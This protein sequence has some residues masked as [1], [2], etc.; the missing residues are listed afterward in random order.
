MALSLGIDTGGTY[1]DAVLFEEDAGVIATA[2][3]LTTRHDFS[4]GIGQ[5]IGAVIG[6]SKIDPSEISLVSL[7]STLATNALVE[8]QGGRVCLVLIGFDRSALSRSG[9]AEAIKDDPVILLEGGHNANGDEVAKP[10]LDELRPRLRELEGEVS[11]YAVAG[12]FGVRNPEHEIQVRDTIIDITSRP[13]TCS[14]ELSSKLDGPRRALTCVLNARLINMVHHLISATEVQFAER[15]IHAPLMVVQGDGAL[16]SSDIAKLKP[17]ETILS[18]PAASLVG[19][20]WLTGL[21]DALISDIG[22]TTTDIAILKDGTPRLDEDGATVGGWRT[23]VEAVA[24]H[25]VGLGGDSEV[26]VVQRGLKTELRLGPRRL[27]PLSL[28][29]TDYPDLVHDTLI[30]QFNQPALGEHDGQFAVVVGRESAHLTALSAPESEILEL[31]NHAPQAL[32]KVISSRPRR[33]AMERLVAHGLVMV[34]GLTPS[35]GAHVLGKHDAWD[36]EA[37]IKGAALFARRKDAQGRPIADDAGSMARWIVETLVHTSAET[38]LAASMEEDN[39][40]PGGLSR[41]LLAA[42]QGVDQSKLV[43]FQIGL[44]VPLIGLGASAA[45]YYPDVAEKLRTDAVIPEHAG[46]ANALGAVVGYV[47][48]SAEA[49]ITMPEAG[50]Y[51]VFLS[52]GPENFNR[53]EDALAFVEA[54][55]SED[56]KDRAIEAGAGEVEIKFSHDDNIAVVE[57]QE[58]LVECLVRASASGRP[59][60][61]M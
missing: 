61:A 60:I 26:Q 50:L 46:V 3:S 51:R 58:M 1:T 11:A 17:I 33:T 43:S 30:R 12:M 16:I 35:D 29:A 18:G 9:L 57:G 5:S 48:V 59:R 39:F 20:A 54:K 47:R 41:E 6:Q 4:I 2:K 22:G 7:S 8:G 49:T 15:G 14:H 55:L 21:T 36:H 13:V 32:D 56:A 53:L 31:L 19:A 27:I 37:A 24:M 25:T 52:G 44:T 34:S 40:S 45:T 38:L 23:M 10:D 28:F 42:N